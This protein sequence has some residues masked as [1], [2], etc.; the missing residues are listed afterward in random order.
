MRK[1]RF[2][3]E[4]RQPKGIS[5]KAVTTHPE[6]ACQSS[7][8][9]LFGERCRGSIQSVGLPP[10]PPSCSA[11]PA[12]S[13]S[14]H[15]SGGRLLWVVLFLL[16]AILPIGVINVGVR[17]IDQR[18]HLWKEREQ[19]ERARS[20]LEALSTGWTFKRQATRVAGDFR[21]GLREALEIGCPPDA[22]EKR[23]RER[24]ELLFAPPFPKHELWI[25]GPGKSSAASAS[26]S[27]L[28]APANSRVSRRAISLV[29]ENLVARST[30]R[31]RTGEE[32]RRA[33]R[34]IHSLFGKKIPP[35]DLGSSQ[36]GIPTPVVYQNRLYWLLWDI[37]GPRAEAGYLLLTPAGAAA[38]SAG[39]QLSLA[40]TPGGNQGMK[41]GFLRLYDD[42]VGDILPYSLSHS[43]CFKAW[44]E[45]LD[46]R[47]LRSYEKHGLPMGV[48]VGNFTAYTMPVPYSTHIAITLLP[49]PPG[50]TTPKGLFLANLLSIACLGLILCRGLLLGAWPEIRLQLRF[51]ILYLLA[52]ALPVTLFVIAGILFLQERER[53]SL[54]HLQTRMQSALRTFE[55]GKER[56]PS[57][58]AVSFHRL[59]ADPAF[60]ADLRL[61]GLSAP[62]ILER[63][64]SAFTGSSGPL[65]LAFFA[66][67]DAEG[68]QA[69]SYSPDIRREDLEGTLRLCRA[70]LIQNI[71]RRVAAKYGISALG[72]DP[73]TEE[74]R[75]FTE[76]YQSATNNNV[77]SE[78]EQNRSYPFLYMIG[79]EDAWQLYDF[80]AV[81]GLER[82][83]VFTTWRDGDLDDRLLKQ[84]WEEVHGSAPDIRITA[85]RTVGDVLKPIT[86]FDRHQTGS[87]RGLSRKIAL[88]AARRSRAVIHVDEDTTVIAFPSDRYRNV[89][90][91]ACVDH[92]SI[93]EE[94]ER[95][96]RSFWFLGLLSLA[97]ISTFGMLTARRVVEPIAEINNALDNVAAGNLDVRVDRQRNDEFGNL[98]DAF[99]M[100]IGGLRERR[101][102]SEL[103]SSAALEAM[104]T[105]GDGLGASLTEGF[106]G[107]PLRGVVLMSDLRGFTTLCEKHAPTEMTALLNRHFT[108]TAAAIDAWGGHVDKFIG[109]AVQAFFEETGDAQ[110]YLTEDSSSF[111]EN[112]PPK[113]MVGSA[114]SPRLSAVE[115]AI[116][117]SLDI[118]RRIE[119]LNQERLEAGLFS[120]QA[121][122][123]LSGGILMGGGLGHVGT[124]FDYALLGPP[125]KTA[126]S[127]EALSKLHPKFP[128]VI[129]AKL[130]S[131]A[132]PFLPLL[133]PLE[134]HEHEARIFLDPSAVA[135]IQARFQKPDS[136][137][138]LA[139][140]TDILLPSS[141][142]LSS[143][144]FLPSSSSAHSYSP[145]SLFLLATRYFSLPT[146]IKKTAFFLMGVALLLLPYA[147]VHT[148]SIEQEAH[149]LE[150]RREEA[151]S[152][153]LTF[154][155]YLQTPHA[156]QLLTE[157]RL[158]RLADDIV[159]ALPVTGSGPTTNDLKT[160]GEAALNRLRTSGL[161][162]SRFLILFHPPHDSQG[163]V[164]T[165]SWPLIMDY[166]CAA[167]ETAL[168]QRLLT[169]GLRKFINGR[170][171]EDPV[172]LEHLPQLLGL[173]VELNFL[174][175]ELCGRLGPTDC[176]G[177]LQWFYWQP[178]YQTIPDTPKLS[179]AK[180][181]EDLS[182]PSTDSR[183]L[184]GSLMIMLPRSSSRF[185]VP[186][187][188]LAIHDDTETALALI[189]DSIHSTPRFPAAI[190][191]AL[192]ATGTLPESTNFVLTA[193]DISI[194]KSMRVIAATPVSPASGEARRVF[195]EYALLLAVFVGGICWARTVF[196]GE[197]IATTLSG[198]LL[199]GLLA[200]SLLPLAATYRL[201]ERFTNERTAS[202][203]REERLALSTSIEDIER[204][205]LLQRPYSW[206]RLRAWTNDSRLLNA[207]NQAS[208]EAASPGARLAGFPGQRAV[209]EFFE[210][211]IDASRRKT[212]SFGVNEV[213]VSDR[214]GWSMNCR[215]L[216]NK[217]ASET[218]ASQFTR[219]IG[220]MSKGILAELQSGDSAGIGEEPL[221][222]AVKG[223][224]TAEIG[225]SILRT[226]F[227]PDLYFDIVQSPG[228]PLT[229]K[230]GS[231]GIGFNHFLIPPVGEP[232]FLIIWFH[233][234]PVS[235]PIWRV[236]KGRQGPFAFFSINRNYYGTLFDPA[237]GNFPPL[238]SLA[239]QTLAMNAP[240]ST[241]FDRGRDAVLA[242]ACI[243]NL[244]PLAVF[245]GL[246]AVA[247]ILDEVEALQGSLLR[248]LLFG[249]LA[250]LLLAIVAASDILDPIR[251]LIQGMRHIENGSFGHRLAEERYDE[252]GDVMRAFN[253][254]ARGLQERE[255]M[256]RM[257]SREARKSTEI[258]VPAA[259]HDS[260]GIPDR[261]ERR[262][263]VVVSLGVPSFDSW[264]KKLDP[265]LLFSALTEL[266]TRICEAVIQ[267]GG[268]VDKVLGDKWLVF[269][270]LPGGPKAEVG[271][272]LRALDRLRRL[273]VAGSLPLPLSAGVNHGPVIAGRLGAGN[274]CD[275]TIIG[276]TVNVAARTQAEAEKLH[277]D[278]FL[279]TISAKD[280]V[281]MPCETHGEIALKGKSL[282]ITLYRLPTLLITDS[283]PG[284]KI[285]E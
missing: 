137:E 82:F 239:R 101:R 259:A 78:V 231:G 210:K 199:V 230:G 154:L 282:P 31:P 103:V 45:K 233:E 163:S 214:Q 189:D 142:P 169:F 172:L 96:V 48:P 255:L 95:T 175:S 22:L 72:R 285:K 216:E 116:R 59:L 42:P 54:Q 195:L 146:F 200:A 15:A 183:R 19:N 256:G 222:N 88:E 225:N 102:L 129:D 185:L 115:R 283:N 11:F 1:N 229:L 76:A 35:H 133:S 23:V 160:A 85:F 46:Y 173:N 2:F 201:S 107:R 24:A 253:R 37:A 223:E 41:S 237:R 168:F 219:T 171:P 258:D 254:M 87:M 60:H 206:Q 215:Y 273:E 250:T 198:Q 152:K 274:R 99:T 178:L 6:N 149:S 248:I 170:I 155:K 147:A 267:E 260:E 208:A 106:A 104:R 166:G 164:P 3:I 89:I 105:A 58:Y 100:M 221:A 20:E 190:K 284:I 8:S 196:S 119:A 138:Y 243:G 228:T 49:T 65:P 120:Y 143:S 182:R 224:M 28:D 131:E 118:L 66:V 33:A 238:R 91:T 281:Q 177:N 203:L 209:R 75:V 261:G 13:G 159:N 179:L 141:S 29:F 162:P 277:R 14:M 249:I 17:F 246:A 265:P 226:S 271:A 212:F 50:F 44:R 123:G 150:T 257:V 145:P 117:A 36:R 9:P 132:G 92:V 165:A 240:L 130:I 71:R 278:R 80:F 38:R 109:D 157:I 94:R 98:A 122:I 62:G 280:L 188:F 135:A 235:G 10:G 187:Q 70:G 110:P 264:Y 134:G 153:N 180:G 156:L 114:H 270:S 167:S 79:R 234:N 52:V 227:G 205:A 202:R 269:F 151:R 191:R 74:D 266:T 5:D 186:E 53:T 158:E 25:F 204:L 211:A 232:R 252:L 176:H 127:L 144:S 241:M 197:A 161:S 27:I 57:E 139:S 39:F 275:Y 32:D 128:I 218:D 192:T 276:D 174:C 63:I 242:E 244:N 108:E 51:G 43:A 56:L 77:L 26:A 126:A 112:F 90:L 81:E 181:A 236:L 121:G 272:A 18:D 148:A 136:R 207:L 93:Q 83:A 68:R 217:L 86:P 61:Q 84:A 97:A 47:R 220:M 184:V 125:L 21:E 7:S 124:R 213:L 245:I 12:V 30:N 263:C 64:R 34:L 69:A 279:M 55:S 251:R 194:G 113:S 193:D 73:L 67:F 268:D 247:P 4:S 262:E 40:A 16:L 140:R 111:S